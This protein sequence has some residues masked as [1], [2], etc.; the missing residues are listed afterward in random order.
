MRTERPAYD[1]L[2]KDAGSRFVPFAFESFG[3]L[4]TAAVGFLRD[5]ETYAK[6]YRSALS[7]GS[8]VAEG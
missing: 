1:S 3:G 5:L 8:S 7:T 6:D 2:A 4:A